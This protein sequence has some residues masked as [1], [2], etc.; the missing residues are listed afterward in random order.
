MPF[1]VPKLETQ[2]LLTVAA[3]IGGGA[4]VLY[5]YT[6]ELE[7]LRAAERYDN[8]KVTKTLANAVTLED[9]MEQV[10]QRPCYFLLDHTIP[11]LEAVFH[12]MLCSRS[13]CKQMLECSIWSQLH[14]L[15]TSRRLP[16]QGTYLEACKQL[17]TTTPVLPPP[18][19]AVHY[20]AAHPPHWLVHY[21]QCSTGS[22]LPTMHM[23]RLI[24]AEQE[25]PCVAQ[26]LEGISCGELV[27]K[28]GLVEGLQNKELAVTFV[29]HGG[30]MTTP[31]WY[32]Y[33]TILCAWEWSPDQIF[34]Q[35]TSSFEV[36]DGEYKGGQVMPI[37]QTIIV[38][39]EQ[40][41]PVPRINTDDTGDN[42][43]PQV[44][45][46]CPTIVSELTPKHL[47]MIYEM[48]NGNGLTESDLMT[49]TPEQ[50]TAVLQE[51]LDA[52]IS[53]DHISTLEIN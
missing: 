30:F 43:I 34:W 28:C 53:A 23:W 46:P 12:L 41:N 20:H 31:I 29:F 8:K 51:V 48:L 7:R 39:L 37:N 33:R 35:H 9:V 5:Y 14:Q 19:L 24:L 11:N 45:I 49:L 13:L 47:N 38:Y 3:C 6:S 2:T 44:G 25:H 26:F 50:R 36:L 22:R 40:V 15:Y 52:Y 1:V 4:A 21:H 17:R 27:G 18:Q 42:P 10:E 16:P 32:R